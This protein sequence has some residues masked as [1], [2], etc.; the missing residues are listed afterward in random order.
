MPASCQA[1]V[2]N[3]LIILEMGQDFAWESVILKRRAYKKRP[4]T[5]QDVKRMI[6]MFMCCI[7]HPKTKLPGNEILGH[8]PVVRPRT[9]RAPRR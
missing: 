1:E 8:K 9:E 5:R 6:Y 3:A 7:T 4:G 2:G